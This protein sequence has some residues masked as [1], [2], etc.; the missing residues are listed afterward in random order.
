REKNAE[1]A[2]PAEDWKRVNT[3]RLVLWVIFWGASIVLVG[4]QIMG[5]PVFLLIVAVM[6]SFLFVLVN[7]ISQGIS[8]WNPISSA[9][10]M[11]VFILAATGLRDARVGFMCASGILIACSEG[12]ELQQERQTRWKLGTHRFK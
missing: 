9:F 11:T 7:G 8:D 4:H 12:C 10:V 5:Q 6:L 1:P 3:L 2:K